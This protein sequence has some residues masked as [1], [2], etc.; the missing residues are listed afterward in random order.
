MQ[1]KFHRLSKPELEFLKDNCNLTEDES[2][3]LDMASKRCSDI[4]IA[5]RLGIC[6]STVTKRKKVLLNK[7]NGFLEVMEEVT[8]IYINGKRVTKDE[9]KNYEI[10][11]E[12]VK[13]ILS[14]KLTKKEK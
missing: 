9:I 13:K 4:Q 5:D 11:L 6:T 14:D 12:S 7:I 1:T 10:Q 2:A 8:T 3:L